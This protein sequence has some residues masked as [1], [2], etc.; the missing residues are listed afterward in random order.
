MTSDPT[1]PCMA[2][3]TVL[4]GGCAAAAAL[5]AGCAQGQARSTPVRLPLHGIEVGGGKVFAEQQIVV[6]QPTAG[7]FRAFSAVCTH[8]GCTVR[9][10]VDGTIKCPCH[11]SRFNAADGTVT[12]GPA[13]QP[14]PERAVTIERDFITVQ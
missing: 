5:A 3:R 2:R 1:A 9:D 11:G 6:T 4:A 8:Q 7:S 14:L 12:R 10:V 13:Q